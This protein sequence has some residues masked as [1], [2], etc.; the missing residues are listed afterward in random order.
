MVLWF[1]GCYLSYGFRSY[2]E[3]GDAYFLLTIMVELAKLTNQELHIVGLD[4]IK[5]FDR[6]PQKIVLEVATVFGLDKGVCRALQ[7]MHS[8]PRRAFKINGC[9]GSF[10]QATNGILQGCPLSVSLINMLTSIWKRAIDKL[11]GGFKIDVNLL[12]PM[13]PLAKQLDHYKVGAIGYADDTY[14]LAPS[15]PPLSAGLRVTE[16]YLVHTTACIQNIV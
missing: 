11:D 15:P 16:K 12:V 3:T 13:P 14:L 2:K 5:I 10:F 1:Y 4:Y 7:S 9:L 6:V 8:S